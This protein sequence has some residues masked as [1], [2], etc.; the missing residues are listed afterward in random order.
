[1][2]RKQGP[3]TGGRGAPAQAGHLT[4][5]LAESG[6]RPHASEFESHPRLAGG[7]PAP[8]LRPLRFAGMRPAAIAA[9]RRQWLR[10]DRDTGVDA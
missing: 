3:P 6:R 2:S 8:P 4:P 7:A 10:S 9:G 5:E 1:M